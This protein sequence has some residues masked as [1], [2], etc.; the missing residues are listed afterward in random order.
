MKNGKFGSILFIL[1]FVYLFAAA[2]VQTA[3]KP[4][5]TTYKKCDMKISTSE[6][7]FSSYVMK[8]VEPSAFNDLLRGTVAG[9]RVR[10]ATGC[11]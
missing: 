10:H 4:I 3:E 1:P 8:G 7:N 9:R 11:I 2:S 5:P 6:R